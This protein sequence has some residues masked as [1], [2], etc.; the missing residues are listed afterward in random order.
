MVIRENA[1]CVSVI[2]R[3]RMC[4]LVIVSGNYFLRTKNSLIVGL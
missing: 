4:Y 3:Y 1:V 2:G